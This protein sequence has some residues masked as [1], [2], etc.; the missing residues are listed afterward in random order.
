MAKKLNI[1]FVNNPIYTPRLNPTEKVWDIIK[2]E[3]RRRDINSKEEL[4]SISFE[5]FEE[6]CKHHS[7][8][9]KFKEKY[10]LHIS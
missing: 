2:K 4:I 1:K 3:I 5:I 6:K 8:I 10:L 9:K 7:L